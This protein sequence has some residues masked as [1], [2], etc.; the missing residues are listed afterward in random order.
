MDDDAVEPAST[1]PPVPPPASDDHPILGAKSPKV[2]Y[3]LASAKASAEAT[4]SNQQSSMGIGLE[5]E[6]ESVVSFLV[7]YLIGFLAFT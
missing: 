5:E 2:K 1:D 6:E 7:I 3:G 4:A